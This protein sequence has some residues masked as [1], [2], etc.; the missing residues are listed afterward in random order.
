MANS[1][2]TQYLNDCL[3]FYCEPNKVFL[4]ANVKNCEA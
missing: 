3:I 4:Y 2:P 1:Q